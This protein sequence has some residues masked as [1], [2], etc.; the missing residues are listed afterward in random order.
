MEPRDTADI[1]DRIPPQD[2]SAEMSTLGG[3]LLSKDAIADALQEIKGP[4]FYRHA[5]E[6]I[7]DAIISVYSRGEPAD[8]IVVADELQRQGNL[9]KVGGA[10]YLA[11]LI[12]T[13]PTAA[14]TAY[15][16]RI[17]R[18]RATMRRLVEAG[19]TSTR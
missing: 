13:V 14:N 11:S 2:E 6:Q 19:T 17:V 15:Y 5:H 18:E 3:M 9:E 8:P 12:A 1:F 16:A 7:F 4:D 10:P